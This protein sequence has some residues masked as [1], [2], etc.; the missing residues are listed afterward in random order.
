MSSWRDLRFGMASRPS[1][2]KRRAY[3][4]PL[5]GMAPRPIRKREN[6]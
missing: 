6:R 3:E 4:N 1:D 2:R 5:G